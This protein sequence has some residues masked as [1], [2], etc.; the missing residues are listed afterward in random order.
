MAANVT[1]PG[2]GVVIESVDVGAGVERQT[3][4]IAS[5]QAGALKLAKLEDAAS[6]SGDA[7]VAIFAVRKA[8]PADLSDT[9]GDYEVLQIKDGLLWTRSISS[10]GDNSSGTYSRPA[11]T[12][13]YAVDDCWSTSTSSPANLTFTGPARASGKP[14]LVTDVVCIGSVHNA[15]APLQLELWVFNAAPTA[16]NDNANHALSDADAAKVRAVFPITLSNNMANNDV[17]Y[18]TGKPCIVTPNGAADLIAQVRVKN[19]YTPSS[20]ESLTF[21]ISYQHVG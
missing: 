21:I 4:E 17:G 12:N 6:A 2:T 8:T 5:V 3:V 10:G 16:V 11:D 1:L 7:G 15:T 13:A 9:D 20:A 18:Y 19:A 14:I